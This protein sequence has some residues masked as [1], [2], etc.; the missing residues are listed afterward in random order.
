VLWSWGP[1][2]HVCRCCG[3]NRCNRSWPLS[4]LC[5]HPG[6]HRVVRIIT[7]V[8]AILI[9]VLVDVAKGGAVH[10]HIGVV[11]VGVACHRLRVADSE[12]GGPGVERQRWRKWREGAS[13]LTDYL[14]NIDYCSGKK[15]TTQSGIEPS[16]SA[17]KSW[18]MTNYPIHQ[19]NDIYVCLRCP[20]SSITGLRHILNAAFLSVSCIL[21]T[22]SPS[23][24]S[25][26]APHLPSTPPSTHTPNCWPQCHFA[27]TQPKSASHCNDHPP[28]CWQAHQKLV[29]HH[30]QSELLGF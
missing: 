16:A 25:L 19:T 3:H 7:D 28:T 17:E 30:A 2:T 12:N 29:G 10:C 15:K 22:T 1:F 18:A 9:S 14:H 4:S 11:T 8:A 24:A 21:L 13:A 20:M 26:L 6:R 5:R 27:F 23:P